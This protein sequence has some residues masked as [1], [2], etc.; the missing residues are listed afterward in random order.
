[1]KLTGNVEVTVQ[2]RPESPLL[3]EPVRECGQFLFFAF[4]CDEQMFCVY[5]GQSAFGS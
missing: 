4:L 3:L 2:L 5:A 1:M